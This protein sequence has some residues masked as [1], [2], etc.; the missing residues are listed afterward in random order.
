VLKVRYDKYEGE[1]DRRFGHLFYK[2]SYSNYVMKFEYRFVGDQALGGPGWAFRNSGIM[3]HGQTPESMKV[4]Q[5]FP[6]SIEV[7][8]LGGKEEGDRPTL[9]LCTPGTNVV[10]NGELFEPHC[11]S[12]SSLTYR[13]DGWVSCEIEVRGNGMIRHRVEGET[14]I[15]YTNPQ[16]DPRDENA[17]VLLENQEMQLTG[18]SISLQAESHS[19]EFRNIFIR[20]LKV[21]DE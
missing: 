3:I 8:L 10:M 6:V 17:K 5:D 20:E 13:G 21:E 1:F 11:T 19:C 12:S 4:D 14:V 9:N 18:G 7:Q 15:E 16:L 2:N